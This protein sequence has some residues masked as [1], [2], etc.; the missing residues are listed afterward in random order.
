MNMFETNLDPNTELLS[1]EQVAAQLNCSVGAIQKLNRTGR[2]PF[3]RINGK[4]VRILRSELDRLKRELA[5]GQERVEAQK[6]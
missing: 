2:L 5:G 3:L 6:P 4:C 1:R